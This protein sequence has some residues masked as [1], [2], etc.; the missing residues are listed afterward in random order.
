[1][2]EDD[3]LAEEKSFKEVDGSSF[4]ELDE[5]LDPLEENDLRTEEEEVL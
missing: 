5:P 4:D 2:F 1:M 3:E